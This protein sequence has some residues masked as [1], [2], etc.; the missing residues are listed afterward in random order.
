LKELRS[1]NLRL[2]EFLG[3]LA[4]RLPF[5]TPPEIKLSKVRRY[6]YETLAIM[7]DLSIDDVRNVVKDVVQTLQD[8]NYDLSST[9]I[10]GKMKRFHGEMFDQLEQM[11]LKQP[12]KVVKSVAAESTEQSIESKVDESIEEVKSVKK[13][14]KAVK[15]QVESDEVKVEVAKKVVKKKVEPE[16][17]PL[18]FAED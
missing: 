12:S 10:I 8:R 3:D 4:R 18:P 15:K 2:A 5:V 16:T 7:F 14:R 6:V 11:K 13:P 1:I 9:S 17:M